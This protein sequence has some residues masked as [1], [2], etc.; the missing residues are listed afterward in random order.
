MITAENVELQIMTIECIKKEA[1]GRYVG[2]VHKREL[3][4]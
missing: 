2:E 4:S 3:H 1:S